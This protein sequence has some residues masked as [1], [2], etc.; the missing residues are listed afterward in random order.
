MSPQ[1]ILNGR[2]ALTTAACLALGAVAAGAGCSNNMGHVDVSVTATAQPISDDARGTIT[3][4]FVTVTRVDV[5]VSDVGTTTE[6]ADDEAEPAEPA[7]P[8]DEDASSG[9][10]TVFE[11]SQQIDLLDQSAAPTFLGGMDVPAGKIKHV[12]LVLGAAPILRI[13]D[14]DVALDC[15]S[16]TESGIKIAIAIPSGAVL[17]ADQSLALVLDFTQA[18]DADHTRLDPVIRATLAE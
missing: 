10:F 14:R 15:P 6:P 7:E 1:N 4:L 12:R 13:G 5:H 17:E 11:G 2:R 16:C 3:G 18:L 8:A 9:W